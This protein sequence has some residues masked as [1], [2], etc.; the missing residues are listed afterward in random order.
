MAQI[1]SGVRAILSIPAIYSMFQGIMGA[2]HTRA[3]FVRYFVRANP[4][5]Q[6]LDIGCGPADILGYLP[7]VEYHGFDISQAYVNQAIQKWGHRAQFHCEELSAV[8]L[9][10]LP[11]FDLVLA[12]GVLHHLDDVS[13][14]GVLELTRSALKPGGRLVT[15]DPCLEP[16]QSAVARF[17]VSRDRGQNV[18]NRSAYGALAHA[19]FDAPRVEVRHQR[20]I[21]YTHCFME[22]TR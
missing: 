4:G 6:V 12:L 22:C 19:V 18:R 1:T 17:L 16:G 3:D 20:W 5:I 7:E 10:R 15:I 13:A 2:N 11:F 14:R 8:A 9:A 21:P